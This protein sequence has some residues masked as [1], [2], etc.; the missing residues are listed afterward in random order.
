MEFLYSLILAAAVT[1]PTG[2]ASPSRVELERVVDNSVVLPGIT[3]FF[4]IQR[5]PPVPCGD[6]I[7]FRG[8][9]ED[10]STTGLT[11]GLY[12][13]SPSSAEVIANTTT[14][15]PGT[16]DATFTNVFEEDC[17]R[18]EEVLFLGPD[19]DISTQ[20]NVYA[21]SS[22]DLSRYLEGGLVVDGEVVRAYERLSTDPDETVFNARFQAP[23]TKIEAVMLKSPGSDPVIIADRTTILPGQ[24]T[25]GAVF[26]QPL[27]TN[28]QGV[29]F[30]ALTFPEIG[31]YRWTEGEGISIIADNTTPVPALGGGVF[32]LF[33]LITTLDDGIVFEA[34][35]AAGT[36]IFIE[37]DG[38]IESLVVPGDTT[39]DGA[40]VTAAGFPSGAGS[41]LSFN[42]KTTSNP[43]EA[44]FVRSGGGPVERILG[45]GDTIE[46]VLVADVISGS[47]RSHVAIRIESQDLETQVI[48]RATFPEAIPAV[49]I[50]SL[51]PASLMALV[52]LLAAAGL[53]LLRR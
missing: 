17:M 10:V 38:V 36:G 51:T 33:G 29:I 18:P 5:N 53:L 3:D 6:Q 37:R 12:A 32:S 14:V 21:A 8:L 4:F 41:L 19:P 1:S 22:G 44:I 40:M 20:G 28:G 16:E 24:T 13:A 39:A 31:I 26:S 15:V 34:S 11:V 9:H 42:A 50:P 45:V 23:S 7:I 2:V 48:Y 52:L 30:H 49:A 25:G 27:A 47:D 46:G 35:Y 43:L